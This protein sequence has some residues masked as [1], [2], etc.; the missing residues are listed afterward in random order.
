MHLCCNRYYKLPKDAIIISLRLARPACSGRLTGAAQARWGVQ[1]VFLRFFLEGSSQVDRIAFLQGKHNRHLESPC[2]SMGSIN[3]G[4]RVQYP[5]RRECCCW[6]VSL[7]AGKSLPSSLSSQP[8]ADGKQRKQ[9]T[10][11]MPRLVS[12][13]SAPLFVPSRPEAWLDPVLVGTR[14]A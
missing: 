7:R 3:W 10:E 11:K 4:T 2:R 1:G 12:R 5:V 6:C 9:Q 8:D 13:R 14:W